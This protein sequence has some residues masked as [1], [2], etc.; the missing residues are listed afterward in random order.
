MN[1]LLD[2]QILGWLLAGLGIVQLVPSAA[3]WIFG[4]PLLPYA[5]SAA[6]A[7]VYGLPL[8]LS[9][10]PRDRRMRNRDGFLVVSAAWAVASVFGAIPYLLSGVLSPVD[11]LFESIAGFTTT[12]ATVMVEIESAP[13][14]LLLWRSLTQWLGG[15]GIIKTA[16]MSRSLN[17]SCHHSSTD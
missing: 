16:P 4:E 2:L 10:R 8:A 13:R 7:L 17:V 15:M 9:V 1:L 12:G 6:A 3:A 5:G 11:A 14:A